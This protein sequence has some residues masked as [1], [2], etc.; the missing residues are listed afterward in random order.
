MG[1]TR[2]LEDDE[3]DETAFEV[4]R[5]VM[6]KYARGPLPPKAQIESDIARFKEGPERRKSLLGNSFEEQKQRRLSG[7]PRKLST[8][9]A[10]KSADLGEDSKVVNSDIDPDKQNTD[11]IK[12]DKDI[13]PEDKTNDSKL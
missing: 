6:D 11:T 4:P 10:E 5:E 7:E 13:K 2:E 9:L 12:D 3:V 1:G 8:S